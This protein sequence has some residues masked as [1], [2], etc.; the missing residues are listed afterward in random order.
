MAVIVV[1]VCENLIYKAAFKLEMR[2]LAAKYAIGLSTELEKAYT[3]GKISVCPYLANG[4][5]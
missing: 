3:M 2:H 4:W 5:L 1:N